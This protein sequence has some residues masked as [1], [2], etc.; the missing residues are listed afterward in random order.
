MG[1]GELEPGLSHAEFCGKAALWL[2]QGCHN[3]APQA[4]DLSSG[5]VD[6][7][8][9]VSCGSSGPMSQWPL[10]T[11]RAPRVLFCCSV[12]YFCRVML[13]AEPAAP[14]MLGKGFI[15]EQRSDPNFSLK[16]HH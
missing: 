13:E 12:C 16:S 11:K 10:L 6:V 1:V 9:H 14:C 3:K 7:S 5:K 2:C 8:F 4:G 15:T